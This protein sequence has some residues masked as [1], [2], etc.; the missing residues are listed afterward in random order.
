MNHLCAQ[1]ALKRFP[2]RS[3]SST[4][5]GPYRIVVMGAAGVGKTCIISQ[6][7]Y[8]KFVTEYKETVEELHRGEYEI[9]GSELVLDILD[10][11]GA[12][13][14]PAM[15][16]LSISTGDAFMLVYS[17]DDEGSFDE[18]KKLRDQI[19][20]QKNNDETIPIVI[21][22][23]KADVPKCTRAFPKETAESTV[24][25]EWGNGYVEVS[26]KEN[27]NIVNIFKELLTQAK[28]PYAL[29]PAVRRRR[30]SLPGASTQKKEKPTLGKQNSC[31]IS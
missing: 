7:L 10:T 30:Q 27:V 24:S 23:N 9:N 31:V 29:S 16:A 22:G 21:V 15:R 13:P 4:K 26:A 3:N 12:Y 11:S 28:V 19:V 5:K 17:I 25:I 8:E 14:F 6:F 1:P 20:T 2:T 18:V